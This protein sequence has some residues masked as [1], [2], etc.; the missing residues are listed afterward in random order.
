MSISFRMRGI[1]FPSFYWSCLACLSLAI[2]FRT[3]VGG[4]VAIV[5]TDGRVTIRLPLTAP[6]I[7]QADPLLFSDD[8]PDS[9]TV[10]VAA[11]PSSTRN[12]SFQWK[13]NIVTTVFWIGEAPTRNN[14]V[15]NTKSSWDGLWV[16]TFGGVDSPMHRKGL[17]PMGFVPSANPFYVA[18]P[19]NDISKTGTKPEAR[20]VVPWFPETFVRNGTSVLKGR[21]LAVR[22]GDRIAYAQWEDCGPFRTDHWQYVFGNERPRPN[23]NGGAGLDVS[24][25][26][27]DFL[28][29]SG[30]DLCDWSFVDVE[31]VPAGPWRNWQTPGLPSL[32]GASRVDTSN[33]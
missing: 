31:D 28:G 21:W 22:H 30:K 5:D 3:A 18:L 11:S 33:N 20:L 9:Q 26:I 6:K 17:L 7:E 1:A 15:P 8:T 19:Y 25:A 24:P 32:A 16:S 2:A 4:T 12:R 27:R 14:P 13:R 23:L 10:S 29:L